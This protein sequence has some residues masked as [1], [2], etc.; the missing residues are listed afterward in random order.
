MTLFESK[1]ILQRPW[2]EGKTKFTKCKPVFEIWLFRWYWP[3]PRW[4]E[5]GFLF[6][7]FFFQKKI[8][9]VHKSWEKCLRN[10]MNPST[11]MNN[12][13]LMTHLISF[14]SLSTI[15]PPYMNCLEANPRHYI[16][17]SVNILGFFLKDK[18]SSFKY[19]HNNIIT[20]EKWTQ[21]LNISKYPISV[22]ISQ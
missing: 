15:P 22:Q 7:F 13:Q 18:D 20:P 5:F 21:F 14:I 4:L 6:S 17:S 9:N 8:S 1:E 12:C 2:T 3:I 16:T 10:S 11:K 19:N